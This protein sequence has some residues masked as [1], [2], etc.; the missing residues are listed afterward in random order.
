MDFTDLR[1]LQAYN[2]YPAVSILLSTHRTHPDNQHDVVL[3]KTLVSKA[4]ERL[5]SEFT[6]RDIQPILQKIDT[7]V[8]AISPEHNLDGM[9]I[10]VNRE[11]GERYDLP[12]PVEERVVIDPTF[13]TRDLVFAFNRSPRYRVLTLS[14]KPTRLF[15][16]VREDLTEIK[17]HGF[18]MTQIRPGGATKLP[19][20]VGVNISAVRDEMHRHFFR[21]VDTA[22]QTLQADHPLPVVLVGVEDYIAFYHEVAPN[23]DIVATLNGSYDVISAHEL[24]KLVWSTAQVGFAKRRKAAFDTLEPAVGAKKFA[25]G[26][27]EVWFTA[28][29]GRGSLLLVEEGYHYP[30]RL[31]ENGTS[32]LPADDPNASDVME[33]AVDEIVEIVMT[34]GGRVVFAEPGSLAAHQ[35]IAM[36]LRY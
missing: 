10:F 13:A 15:E 3:L 12:F 24:G 2:G 16:G 11:F 22:L 18:P 35:Q 8:D 21:D 34:K 1:T 4:K 26:I 29:E 32:L 17:D 7:L 28:N 25:G 36:V 19:G 31:S 5:L 30:A 14:E 9:A 27:Q 6:A 23:A 33:D 20:G